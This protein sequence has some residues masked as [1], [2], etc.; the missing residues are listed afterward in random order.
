MSSRNKSKVWEYY[1]ICDDESQVQCLTCKAYLSRGGTGKNASTSPLL[2][3]LK[4]KHLELYNN[5]N[6]PVKLNNSSDTNIAPKKIQTKLT[7]LKKWEFSDPRAEKLNRT[8]GEMI[9]IDNQP[10]S[11]VEDAGNL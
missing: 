6:E 5:L 4:Y 8:I 11:I 10:F 2:K 1:T 7:D 9:A 3:H